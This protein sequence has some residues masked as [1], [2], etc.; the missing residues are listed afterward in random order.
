MRPQMRPHRQV[1]THEAEA[2]AKTHSPC[3]RACVPKVFMRPE[4]KP[5]TR[6]PQAH[7]PSKWTKGSSPSTACESLRRILVLALCSD[8]YSIAV[9]LRSVDALQP[10]PTAAVRPT[11]R[12]TPRHCMTHKLFPPQ[13][14]PLAPTTSA[15][16]AHNIAPNHPHST[17]HSISFPLASTAACS[18]SKRLPR[19]LLEGL[20]K[21]LHRVS[22][23]LALTRVLVF[24]DPAPTEPLLSATRAVA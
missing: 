11:R 10:P 3:A 12:V 7:P 20:V 19:C 23:V 9:P 4:T 8:L 22:E 16:P 24:L 5:I 2:C 6:C 17:P 18:S 14:H 13:A 1:P 15:A 21:D